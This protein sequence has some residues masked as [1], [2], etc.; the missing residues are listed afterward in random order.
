MH[1]LQ[2]SKPDKAELSL[3]APSEAE[4]QCAQ[5][6]K[7]G[8][9]S[10]AASCVRSGATQAACMVPLASSR[11][12]MCTCRMPTSHYTP[13]SHFQQSDASDRPP[14]CPHCVQ[15]TLHGAL[16]VANAASGS[17]YLTLHPVQA[18]VHHR[19]QLRALLP[20]TS[21]HCSTAVCASHSSS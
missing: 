10:P 8:V 6:C 17:G 18:V 7:D 2:A 14:M 12:P 11:G 20:E 9:V 21:C 16:L 15:A 19:Y 3:Q 4:S 1:S 13:D 5:M